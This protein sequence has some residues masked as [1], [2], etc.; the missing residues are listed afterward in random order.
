MMIQRIVPHNLKGLIIRFWPVQAVSSQATAQASYRLAALAFPSLKAMRASL[1]VLST[2]A[3]AAFVAAAVPLPNSRQLE[4]MDLEL[5]QFFHFSIPTFWDPPEEYLYTANPTYHNCATT[6]IDHSNQTGSYYPCLDPVLFNPTNFSA[7]DW[8]ENAAALGTREII[9]TAH[10]EGGFALWPSNFTTYSVKLS[11]RWRGGQGDVL[12]EFADAANRWGIKISYYLNVACDH[13]ATIVE[14]ITPEEFIRRQVGMVH[15]VLTQYGPVNRFWFDGT[16]GYPAD[17]NVTDLWERVYEEIRSVSPSTMIS[18]YRGDICASI[19]TLYTSNGP[20]PNSTDGSAC[21]SPTET[22]AIFHPTE[23]H[24]ITAQMGPDGNT[25]DVPTYW[26]WHNWA[27]ARNISGCPWVGHT[28]ASRIFDSFIWTVGH[29][30]T[31]NFNCPAE[32][33]GRMNASLSAVMHVAGAALNATFRA[34][35]LVGVGATS[36]PCGTPIEID[37]PG[38]GGQPFDYVVSM[39][40]LSF[41]QRVANYSFEFMAVGGDVWEMLVP[42]VISNKSASLTDRPDG[43]DPRDSY[44]GHKRIDFPIVNTSATTGAAVKVAK[45]RFNCIRSLEDPI[46]IRSIELREKQVPWEKEW[47]GPPLPR[48]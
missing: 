34:P 7:D 29:G 2:V 16:T 42:P 44:L 3:A 14:K 22:G 32:R 1:R 19:G 8:M 45:V 39:E 30:A 17:T 5:T 11:T 46:Y 18:P 28:N 26:F 13:Y 31:L 20:V 27:C 43:K 15:E 12:R 37:L 23:M 38:G 25:D 4:F 6:T 35:P 48:E 33:T 21:Q 24:G 10:H 41:G 40:D 47:R 9:L 36:V